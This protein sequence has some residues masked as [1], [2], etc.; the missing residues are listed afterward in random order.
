MSNICSNLPLTRTYVFDN[1]TTERGDT[2]ERIIKKYGAIILL[3]VVVIGG[4]LLLSS[5][6]RYLNDKE[7][8]INTVNINKQ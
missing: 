6:L 2:M 7:N 1:I 4:V 3:Y 8:T 5:R